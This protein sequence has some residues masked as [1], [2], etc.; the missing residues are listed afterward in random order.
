MVCSF[1]YTCH[2]RCVLLTSICKLYAVK[3][4][5]CALYRLQQA[6]LVMRIPT[7][8]RFTVF[9]GKTLPTLT[10]IRVRR[11]LWKTKPSVLAGIICASYFWNTFARRRTVTTWNDQKLSYGLNNKKAVLSYGNRA[12]LLYIVIDKEGSDSK[13]WWNN[14]HL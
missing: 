14:R 3:C 7:W 2:T 12:M 9:A 8:L 6:R 5:L 1:I 11:R 13:R 4:S 10:R